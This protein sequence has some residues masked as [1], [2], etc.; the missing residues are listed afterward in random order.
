MK[1]VFPEMP[2]QYLWWKEIAF[3]FRRG[4]RFFW[5]AGNKQGR[6]SRCLKSLPEIW[7]NISWIFA[8]RSSLPVPIIIIITITSTVLPLVVLAVRPDHIWRERVNI[9]WR[10]LGKRSNPAHDSLAATWLTARVRQRRL[11]QQTLG[12]KRHAVLQLKTYS[13]IHTIPLK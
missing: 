1:N 2:I 8:Y 9:H 11:G 7:S 4:L 10:C 3:I 13:S 5:P 6:W 12:W